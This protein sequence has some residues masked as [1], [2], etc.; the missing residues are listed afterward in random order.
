MPWLLD[1]HVS[2]PHIGNILS[3][4]ASLS[5]QG[6]PYTGPVFSLF[7]YSNRG[8]NLQAIDEVAARLA[9]EHGS[10]PTGPNGRD[11]R[12]L[13]LWFLRDRK[14]DQDKTVEK[15]A[16][17]I[18]SCAL[19]CKQA[20]PDKQSVQLGSELDPQQAVS[21]K[22]IYY[23]A[24]PTRASLAKLKWLSPSGCRPLMLPF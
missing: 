2:V 12:D 6:I 4:T 14:F 21:M 17:A 19:H 3:R 15:L 7:I 5:S 22:S 13:I 8:F 20:F 11:D 9:A 24:L 10:L 18:V 1:V 23:E 16:T